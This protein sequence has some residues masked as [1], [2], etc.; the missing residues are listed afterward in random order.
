MAAYYYLMSSLPMLRA[1]G[2]L[3]LTYAQFLGMCKSSVSGAR[4]ALLEG[5]TLSSD[6]LPLLAEWS[7]F[8]RALQRE[9][10]RYR[11]QRAGRPP[12]K[13]DGADETLFK[14]VSAAVGGKNPLEAEKAL[15]SLQLRKLD[16]LIGM[17]YF[18][19]RALFGYALKLKLLERK[20]IFDQKKGKT[21]LDRILVGLQKQILMGER[22]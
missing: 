16:E 19:E 21:E 3:P 8:Y 5:L 9:L 10:T 13:A 12:Q 11:N 22:E 1:E 18:D 4:Y 20:N 17:H 6:E 14:E 7:G 15:L 2:P